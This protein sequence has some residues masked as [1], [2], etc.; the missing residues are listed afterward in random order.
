[1]TTTR[2]RRRSQQQQQL[3][4][5]YRVYNKQINIGGSSSSSSSSSKIKMK[6]SLLI[7][8][9]NILSQLLLPLVLIVAWSSSQTL[10]VVSAAD[11]DEQWE[12][13]YEEDF[14]SLSFVDDTG[15]GSEWIHDDYSAPE[16]ALDT[17]MDD[18][19]LLYHNDYG[20]ENFVNELNTFKTFR[21]EFTFGKDSW[22]TV[23]M[24]ARDWNGDGSIE[25]PPIFSIKKQ[26]V[27]NSRHVGHI[28]VP[29]HTGGILIRPT[30]ALPEY[31]RIEYKLLGI[32]FGGKRN[33]KLESED[34]NVINGYNI[35]SISNPVGGCKTQ[36]PWGEG[37]TTKGGEP[38]WTSSS[39]EDDDNSYCKWQSLVDGKYGYNGF[40]YL[41]IVDIPNITPRNLHFYHLHRKVL[42]DAF[43]IHDDRA[44]GD[45]GKG[46][47]P[48]ICNAATNK[49][50]N[51]TDSNYNTVNMWISGLP[52]CGTVKDYGK[53][54]GNR[55]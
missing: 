6:R 4:P 37:S 30:K 40:H 11:V 42:I 13:V 1:M 54:V 21:K 16:N 32:N 15:E 27:G 29:D 35:S 53:L 55:Q 44:K 31:Y 25:N 41:S 34:G 14:S 17:I 7:R 26:E 45:N 3:L 39:E 2:R 47:G 49:Y 22:L 12:L 9:K 46:T 28:N 52:K 8:L 5:L 50:Y 19:G 20:S 48:P 10:V 43:S 23:S 38:V 51:Y 36:H 33:G 24:S 18:N